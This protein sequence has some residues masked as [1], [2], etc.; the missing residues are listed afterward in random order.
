[1]QWGRVGDMGPTPP[2]LARRHREPAARPRGQESLSQQPAGRGSSVLQHREQAPGEA[3]PPERR[4]SRAPQ[5]SPTETVLA[6]D[7]SRKGIVRVTEAIK[8][9]ASWGS[10]SAQVP[11][12]RQ[13]TLLQSTRMWLWWHQKGAS[14]TSCAPRHKSDVGSG[15]H[16]HAA[17]ALQP[18]RNS[19]RLCPPAPAVLRSRAWVWHIIPYLARLL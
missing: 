19:R 1:M 11:G 18:H 5:P 2:L 13:P 17:A 16:P 15:G 12:P 8:F 9:V 3:E 6:S 7:Q 4:N 14:Y 10:H